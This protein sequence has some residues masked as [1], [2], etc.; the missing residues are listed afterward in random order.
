MPPLPYAE[1]EGVR[2]KARG[3]SRPI[4]AQ[5]GSIGQVFDSYVYL[6]FHRFVL[7]F[8]AENR[9]KKKLPCRLALDAA[10]AISMLFALAF[11]ITGDFA[12][13]WAG[14]AALALF[15]FHNILNRR[16]FCGILKGR[17]GLRRIL[18]TAVN[19][20]LIVSAV[21]VFITG[22]M[23]SKYI[24][25]FLGI[26][27]GM[28]A[29]QVHS[30]AAYWMLVLASVHLGLHWDAL[31]S[32]MRINSPRAGKAATFALFCIAAFGI[33]AW[34]ERGMYEK[35]FLGY[36]FDFWSPESPQIL[37]FAENLGIAALSAAT[38][39]FAA[40]AL[41]GMMNFKTAKNERLKNE[42]F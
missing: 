35:L 34:G 31:S 26:S 19:M 15:A 40:R 42:L 41:G 14:L 30:T 2:V 9:M 38:A 7:K 1:G 16:W 28:A 18:N 32:K 5:L 33:W 6:Y 39:R 12:H 21:L 20:S 3:W 11:R 17:Y 36:S 22:L 8:Q 10:M 29:R 37:F 25:G 4:R 24:P 13:E 23:H 27:G